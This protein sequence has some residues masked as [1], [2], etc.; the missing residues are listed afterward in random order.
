MNIVTRIKNKFQSKK[1]ISN[2][3]QIS[4]G[5]DS[6][7]SIEALKH[8]KSYSELLKIYVTSTKRNIHMKNC[9]KVVFFIITMGSLIAIVYFFYMALQYSFNNLSKFKTLNDVS[10]EAIL[11]IVTVTFPAISSL[12]VAFIKIPQIIAEY[13]FNIEEDNYMNSVIKNIQDYDKSMFAM[14]HQIEEMLF[15]HKDQ[16][17]GSQDETI[18]KLPQKDVS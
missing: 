13:L 10:I 1:N 6:T 17:I 4:F 18:E 2:N 8:T 7:Q 12:I 3:N 16:N 14:E 11:S 5:M 9:F 15:N